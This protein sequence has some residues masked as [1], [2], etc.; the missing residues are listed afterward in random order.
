MIDLLEMIAETG[1][2]TE[3]EITTDVMTDE[4]IEGTIVV[5][6]E[7]EM[8]AI[9][10]EIEGM[11]VIMTDIAVNK[12]FSKK[13]KRDNIMLYQLFCAEDFAPNA[14]TYFCLFTWSRYRLN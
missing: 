2:E 9:E 6:I 7:E 14:A 5:M 4:T 13:F 3:V 8:I 12:S 11:I 10:E 1:K